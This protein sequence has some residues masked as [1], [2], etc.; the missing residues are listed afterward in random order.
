MGGVQ[1][2]ARRRLTLSDP[3]PLLPSVLAFPFGTP[4]R[5]GLPLFSS[6]LYD[7]NIA[8]Y[9]RVFNRQNVQSYTVYFV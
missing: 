2:L 4:V 5:L 3:V 7:T 6:V 9:N 1:H 8:R